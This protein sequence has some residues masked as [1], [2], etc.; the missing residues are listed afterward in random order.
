MAVSKCGS[1]LTRRLPLVIRP[2]SYS[3]TKTLRTAALSPSSIVNRSR[4]QSQDAPRRLSWL[5]MVPPDSSFHS[6]TLATKSS[7]P[8]SARLTPCSASCRST[9]ICVA[10]PAWSVPGCHSVSK[11][12]IRCQRT[13][14]SWSVLFSAWPMCSEPVTLGGG[15]TMVKVSAPGFAFAPAAKQPCASQSA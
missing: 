10:M 15:M 9:T 3:S 1:Q 8:M 4:D 11:P 5:T 6:Q 14:M 7:R 2:L 12:R 13:R